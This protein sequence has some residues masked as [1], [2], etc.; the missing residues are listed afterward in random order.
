MALLSYTLKT[1]V[2]AS[3]RAVL[4]MFVGFGFAVGPL[5][6][7][8]LRRST[9]CSAVCFSDGVTYGELAMNVGAATAGN[10]VG[11]FALVSLTQAARVT[12]AIE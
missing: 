5:D 1:V 7:S 6:H 11:G 12:S 9:C 3:S 2:S 4:T 10:I 8:S